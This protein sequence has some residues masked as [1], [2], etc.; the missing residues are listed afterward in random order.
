MS[1]KRV[2]RNIGIVLLVAA[3]VM[4]ILIAA[5]G[6][7]AADPDQQR[8]VFWT[9]VP[10]EAGP[11]ALA[12]A[13]NERMREQG[14]NVVAVHER[15]VNDASGNTRLDTALLSG[16]QIDLYVNYSRDTMIR[17]ASSGL[18]TDL[19]P[20]IQ[21]SGF[22]PEA[23]FGELADFGEFEGQV[24]SLPSAKA[25]NVVWYNKTEFDRRGITI[26]ENW[27]WEDYADI[28]REL[29]DADAG[30]FGSMMFAGGPG[31]WAW[32]GLSY[33]GADWRYA[34]DGSSNLGHPL[35]QDVLDIH[36]RMDREDLSQMPLAEMQAT[37]TSPHV[38]FV[39]GNVMMFAASNAWVVRTIVDRE[40]F[41]VDFVTA[42]APVPRANASNVDPYD[43][44]FGQDLPVMGPNPGDP[45]LAWE[46]MQFF[47]TEGSF[48]H[49]AGGRAPAWNGFDPELIAATFIGDNDDLLYA[50]S[51]ERYYFPSEFQTSVPEIS[52]ASAELGEL[53]REEYQRALLGE[54]SSSTAV[55][56]AEQR[57]NEVIRQASSR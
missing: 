50:P 15:F 22:D 16:E 25:V 6:R 44:V 41:P 47:A 34:A 37:R 11:D 30:V 2:R 27:T 13:F 40:Q 9:G 1:T 36:V 57:S 5:G 46:F 20:F 8:I 28:A 43:H 3:L 31:I 53:I 32:G 35:F 48:Y 38:E 29:T 24:F 51:F 39:R 56:N 4:P 21:N 7:E 33:F 26:P 52:V 12:E 17:R 19:T 10:G 45:E 54:I 49:V 55:Q 14:R 23:E 42:I 18:A